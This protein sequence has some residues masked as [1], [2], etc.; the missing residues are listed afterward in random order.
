VEPWP[1]SLNATLHVSSRG[2]SKKKR[3]QRDFEARL[4]TRRWNALR[5]VVKNKRHYPKV[6]AIPS[7]N[8]LAGARACIYWLRLVMIGR[9]QAKDTHEPDSKTPLRTKPATGS[10]E[11]GD[12]VRIYTFTAR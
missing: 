4:H 10:R 6:S 3:I 1:N 5:S 11:N 7:C 8:K 9:L 12:D 2:N